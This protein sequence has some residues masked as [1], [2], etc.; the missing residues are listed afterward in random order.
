MEHGN[1]LRAREA[2]VAHLV[3]RATFFVLVASFFW[4]TSFLNPDTP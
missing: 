2:N 3:K 4:N 1:L